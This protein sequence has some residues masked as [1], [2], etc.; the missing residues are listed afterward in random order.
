MG[1]LN[2]IARLATTAPA[3][4]ITFSNASGFSHASEFG[5]VCLVT[6]A[7]FAFF[8]AGCTSPVAVVGAF[9]GA[10]F[11]PIVTASEELRHVSASPG[12]HAD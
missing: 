4:S 1:S 9:F 8:S 3:G 5:A 2:S 11:F 6:Y 12:F 10:G 7:K